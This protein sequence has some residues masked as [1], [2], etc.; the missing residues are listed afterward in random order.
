MDDVVAAVRRAQGL[1]VADCKSQSLRVSYARIQA[2][3]GLDDLG[4]TVDRRDR[5]RWVSFATGRS[6]QGERNVGGTRADVEEADHPGSSPDEGRQRST[7]Q[8]DT[9]KPAVDAPEVAQVA[10]KRDGIIQRTVQQLGST[11]E[12]AHRESIQPRIEARPIHGGQGYISRRIEP[13]SARS[14]FARPDRAKH[15][16]DNRSVAGDDRSMVVPGVP[17]IP[18]LRGERVVLRPLREDDR[19]RLREILAEPS[20]AIWWDTRG[21]DVSLDELYAESQDAA[22]GVTPFAID[23]DGELI[24]TIEYYEKSEPDYRHASIDLLVDTAHQNQGFGSEA[25]RTLAHY[26]FEVRGHHRLTID[27]AVAN[28]RAVRAYGR[29]GFRPVGIMRDYERGLDGSWH[30]GLLMDMLPGELT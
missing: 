28:E 10:S 20:V 18:V 22:S 9:A 30:D 8:L 2:A 14:S 13:L 5:Q 15:S 27:P 17:D 11:G 12:S 4:A 25:I 29:V 7:A 1:T 26:L 24:G 3:R 21:P 23:L 16:L 19:P 6:R